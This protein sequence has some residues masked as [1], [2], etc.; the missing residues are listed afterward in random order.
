MTPSLQKSS[1]RS[2]TVEIALSMSSA[3]PKIFFSLTWG[4]LSCEARLTVSSFMSC[5]YIIVVRGSQPTM[6]GGQQI[7]PLFFNGIIPPKRKKQTIEVNSAF[8]CIWLKDLTCH[9]FTKIVLA[10]TWSFL[11]HPITLLSGAFKKIST[12]GEVFTV[13]LHINQTWVLAK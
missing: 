1:N 13:G 2:K 9:D 7:T 8:I 3:H 6:R 11:L 4:K 12:K 10:S 5:R